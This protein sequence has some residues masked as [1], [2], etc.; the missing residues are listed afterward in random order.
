MSPESLRACGQ[1]ENI[2]NITQNPNQPSLLWNGMIYPLL[3]THIRGAL[4]YQGESNAGQWQLYT[5]LFPGMIND[6]RAKWRTNF[7]FM[8]VQLAAYAA[9]GFMEIRLAQTS[10][11]KLAHVGMGTAVDLGDP[12]SP[13]HPIHPRNKREV[14]ERLEFYAARYIYGHNV[15]W[16]GALYSSWTWNRTGNEINANVKFTQAVDGLKL[17][18]TAFCRTCCTQGSPFEVLDETS[19]PVVA[20]VVSLGNNELFLRFSLEQNRRPT[21]L[22]YLWFPYAECVLAGLRNDLPSPPFHTGFPI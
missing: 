17:R 3:N 18:G 6:W 1:K 16:T 12:D 11:L 4:W 19:R 9:S 13:F 5:C 15:D 8:F 20:P 14:G 22:R 2:K 10:A 7:E 21:H